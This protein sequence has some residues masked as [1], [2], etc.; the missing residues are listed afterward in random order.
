MNQLLISYSALRRCIGYAAF[1]LPVILVVGSVV[2]H[3]ASSIRN[4]ISDYYYTFFTSYFT[5]TLCAISFFLF[6]YRGYEKQDLVVSKIMSLL[7]MI[8]VFNPCHSQ[9]IDYRYNL[10]HINSTNAQNWI[11]NISAI[12]FFLF[13]AYYSMFLFTKTDGMVTEKKK[14]RNEIY[15]LC[16][17]LIIGSLIC[18]IICA[19]ILNI[20]WPILIFE[21]IILWSFGF[22]WLVK[23][24]FILQDD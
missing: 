9:D 2:T 23:G 21:T 11:H 10:I 5:G 8:I 3:G 15:E 6:T 19:A 24:N 20:L 22:S 18:I 14:R 7:M 4:S 17:L 12:L 13:C 1:L 16:G